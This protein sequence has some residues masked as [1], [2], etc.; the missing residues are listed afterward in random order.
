MFRCWQPRAFQTDPNSH[1]NSQSHKN[2]VSMLPRR[3]PRKSL[4]STIDS[5]LCSLS[6]TQAEVTRKLLCALASYV[7]GPRLHL[8]CAGARPFLQESVSEI[9]LDRVFVANMARAA[10]SAFN[11]LQAGNVLRQ[12]QAHRC[13]ADGLE[14]HGAVWADC[15]L[16]RH[17]EQESDTHRRPEQREIDYPLG[18]AQS[19]RLQLRRKLH[20]LASD[21]RHVAW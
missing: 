7:M 8:V 20:V 15:D 14:A 10:R 18:A 4:L 5:F 16:G 13:A 9:D 6:T 1:T 19:V 21:W 3:L 17:G 2:I 12:T 11:K